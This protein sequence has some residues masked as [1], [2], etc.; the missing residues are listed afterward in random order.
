MSRRSFPNFI[1][2]FL[3]T[4]KIGGFDRRICE[5]VNDFVLKKADKIVQVSEF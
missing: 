4:E 3:L 1:G 5:K 2:K